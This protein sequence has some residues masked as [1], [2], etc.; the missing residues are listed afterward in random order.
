MGKNKKDV[1]KEKTLI[2]SRAVPEQT[3]KQN[4]ASEQKQEARK[5]ELDK[6]YTPGSVNP[7]GKIEDGTDS[8]SGLEKTDQK[9]EDI[10]DKPKKDTILSI[11]PKDKEPE[12]K[13]KKGKNK[14]KKG[15]KRCNNTGLDITK[16]I[17]EAGVCP[18][19]NGSPFG[20]PKK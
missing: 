3:P 2:D 10:K 9:S 20:E 13:E 5:D 12:D 14:E 15:C 4:L 18:D 19:C 17:V 6:G 1:N 7:G 11:P 16:P 8:F